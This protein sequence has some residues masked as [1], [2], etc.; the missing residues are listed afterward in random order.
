MISMSMLLFMCFFGLSYG[1]L[2]YLYIPEIV[3]PKYVSYSAM[4]NLGGVAFSVI[5]FPLIEGI[6][7]DQNPG[8]LF[9][10]FFVWTLV[11]MIINQ[12]FMVETKDKS[13]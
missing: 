5:I 8:Y 1:A 3:E 10:L 9:L 4:A 2:V 13:R 12:K 7:P 11:S 6:L